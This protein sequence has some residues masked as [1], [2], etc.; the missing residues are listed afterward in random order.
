[1]DGVDFVAEGLVPL[2]YFC[3]QSLGSDQDRENLAGLLILILIILS[4]SVE[5]RKN[6]H[7]VRKD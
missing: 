7:I 3:G 1:M 4:A 2:H 6:C 5:G